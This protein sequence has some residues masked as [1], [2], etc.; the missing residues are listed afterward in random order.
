MSFVG[1]FAK[2]EAKS[3]TVGVQHA[4]TLHYQSTA[5]IWTWLYT[6]GL[7]GPTNISTVYHGNVYN[8][9]TGLPVDEG[10]TVSVG[11]RLRFGQS[12]GNIAYTTTGL[13]WDTPFGDWMPGAVFPDG[14]TS[15]ANWHGLTFRFGECREKY[16]TNN[17]DPAISSEWASIR[18]YIPLSVNPPTQNISRD[19]DSQAKLSCIGNVCTVVSPGLIRTDFNFSPTYGKF[20]YE[21][22]GMPS[23]PG[24]HTSWDVRAM[25]DVNGNVTTIPFPARTISFDLTAVG[26]NTTPNTP[27]ITGPTTGT[28]LTAYTFSAQA[29]DP[30]NDTLRYGFD[31]NRDNTVDEWVPATGFVSSNTSQS[32]TH[33][34]S[35][36]GP[37]TFQVLTQDSR[38]ASSA[39][40]SHTITLT[41]VTNGSCGVA[42]GIATSTPPSVGLCTT[43]TPTIVLGTG[44]YT[45]SCLGIG[46]GTDMSCS[47]PYVAPPT[48]K[49]C[50]N[51]CD[52][53]LDR[54]GQTFTMSQSQTKSLKACYNNAVSCTD[55]TGDV[56]STALWTDSNA[57]QNVLSFPSGGTLQSGTTSGSEGFQVVYSGVTKTATV[58]VSC[59]PLTCASA[60]SITD[61]YCAEET[62]NTGVANGCGSTLTCPGTRYCDT[63]YREVSP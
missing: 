36:A 39:F 58:Q 49:I 40:V 61:T 53:A 42:N 7:T 19:A 59:V 50:E 17:G 57:P 54:T 10:A 33:S 63:S 44:P 29:A 2:A 21:Y 5:S 34:W 43:G 14:P 12:L 15:V 20:Y 41:S 4:G 25:G 13:T 9:D 28:P 56:T 37:Y 1:T 27:T 6:E 35:L 18:I 3:V 52:S 60:R 45:W 48:L 38:G 46:G 22:K 31:W 11:T 16:Y 8:E 51:S 23:F 26:G 24:C 30:D 47:A 32:V 55:A 62:R